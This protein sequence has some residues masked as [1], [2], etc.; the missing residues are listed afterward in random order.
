MT[1]AK[2]PGLISSLLL[3]RSVRGIDGL[4]TT[5]AVEAYLSQRINEK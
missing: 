5:E 3:A 1:G 2:I 4:D